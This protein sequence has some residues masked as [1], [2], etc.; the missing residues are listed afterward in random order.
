MSIAIVSL[1]TE[2]VRGE[3]VNTN[4]Q[5]LAEAVS[6]AGHEVSE[7]VSVADDRSQIIEC[8]ARV[9]AR[10]EAVLCTGGLGPTTDDLTTE[11][12]AEMLGQP[13]LL[14]AGSLEHIRERFRRAGRTMAPSNE[15]QALFPAG[16]RILSN[17]EG[18]APGFAVTVGKAQVFCMPGVPHEM[19][20]MFE[21]HVRAALPMH[22]DD[23]V[24]QIRLNT[25]GWPES[26][27]NDALAGVEADHG[28]ILGYRAHF[29]E[30]QVK[31]LARGRDKEAAEARAR[32][33][34][35]V[36]RERLGAIVFSSG[37]TSL[38]AAVG[39]L[40]AQRGL[41]L[42][43]AESCTGGLVAQL[44]TENAG[45]SAYFAGGVVSYSNQV[46]QDVLG[47]PEELLREH[48]A[49]SQPVAEAMARGAHRVLN[50][51]V[52]LALTGVA[53]PA[54]GSTDKP[55]GTV[56]IA[57]FDGTTLIHE[58]AFFPWD[59]RR[60]QLVSAFKGLSLVRQLVAG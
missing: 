39:E 54:G 29:P 53:G 21:M 18:T 19:R 52:A 35:E 3:L 45:S 40:L 24:H 38:A 1:G 44:I 11:A 5:W 4:S 15:K 49:V 7:M 43:L 28:V 37:N 6:D 48:G 46:K 23:Y 17:P 58:K 27:V 32:A 26:S 57:A 50:A 8:L 30:I 12:V 10:N 55:V 16:A 13:L 51:S 33:A 25:F 9:A 60:V 2:V 47:V 56:H 20:A 42:G 14:D 36:V 22:G 31:V 34:V 59:R 41:M